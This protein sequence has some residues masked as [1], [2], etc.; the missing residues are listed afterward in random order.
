MT[1]LV[2]LGLWILLFTV[3]VAVSYCGQ[4]LIHKY[5]EWRDRVTVTCNNVADFDNEQ[6]VVGN[7]QVEPGT[8]KQIC[9]RCHGEGERS[10]FDSIL[11]TGQEYLLSPTEWNRRV[12]FVAI[13]PP[14]EQRTMIKCAACDGTGYRISE[15]LP[16]PGKWLQ[17][18]L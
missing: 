4:M 5:F 8:W 2:N 13:M 15:A 1:N 7:V 9:E 12:Q 3:G 11:R 6:K 16:R 10:R 18:N 17:E 14:E